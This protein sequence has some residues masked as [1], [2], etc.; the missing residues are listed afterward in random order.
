MIV[1]LIL[2]AQIAILICMYLYTKLI[3]LDVDE[4]KTKVD[5]TRD[6]IEELSKIIRFKD[7]V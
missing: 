1:Y 4:V 2:L 6:D 7:H 3:F 5:K